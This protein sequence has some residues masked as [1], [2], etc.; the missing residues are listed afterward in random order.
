M[1]ALLKGLLVQKSAEG[2]IVDVSGVGYEVMVSRLTLDKLPEPGTEVELLI[3]THVAEGILA[4]YGFSSG[5]ERNF[6]KKVLSVSGIGPKLA[7]SILSGF[8]VFELVEAILSENISKLTSI[9]GIGRKT[10][11]R[12]VMELKDKLTGLCASGPDKLS[13][14]PFGK[15]QTYNEV[16]SALVNLGYHRHTAEKALAGISL[17]P[18][19]SLESVLKESLSLLAK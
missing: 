11:E 4:L 8:P 6:F 2:L 14:S 18:D 3:Y 12:M 13:M 10:A 17:K 7:L 16:L 1:I 19:S 15:N 9:S 5:E